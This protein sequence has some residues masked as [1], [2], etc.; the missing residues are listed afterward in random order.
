MGYNEIKQVA[1]EFKILRQLHHPN[2]VEY[3]NHEDVEEQQ[4][5]YIYMEY[6]DGGDL[7]QLIKKFKDDGDYIPEDLLWQIFTQ[8]LM[9]LYRCHN[10]AD[11]GKV[12]SIFINSPDVEPEPVDNL[13]VIIHRDIK[14][15][16]IFLMSDEY[17][18]KLGD[19]GLAKC[20]SSTSQFAKTYVGTPYYMP[21]EVIAGK[22][23]KP[24]CDIWSLGCVLY[25]LCALKPPFQAKTHAQ[26]EEKIR[27][28]KYP[29]IPEHYSHRIRMCIKACLITDPTERATANQLLQNATLKI[30]RKEWEM[31]QQDIR[32]QRKE[33]E[34]QEEEKELKRC[35]GQ[36]E[37]QCRELNA[38]NE[39]IRNGYKRE[40]NY[41]LERQ[42]NRILGEL[43]PAMRQQLMSAGK[44]NRTPAHRYGS[45]PTLNSRKL[46]GP[47]E[48]SD[49]GR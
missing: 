34:L 47:R 26:L 16:N 23:Y 36:L 22:P 44:E 31:F 4:M 12:D 15:D 17:T 11:I 35:E 38:K 13:H 39:E 42:L 32:L 8:V 49:Y 40:F 1:A 24:V 19:F 14:P 9:A 10:G 46:K 45:P 29:P 27:L 30:Y 3:L 2:I 33:H 21:P 6:C 28:G 43:P 20:L 25:E 37:D 18:V 41:V 7:A 48:L 5:L